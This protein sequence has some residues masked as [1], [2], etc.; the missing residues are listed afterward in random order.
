MHDEAGWYYVQ[1]NESIG[2]VTLSQLIAV[3][4]K[5]GGKDAL[6][7]GPSSTEWT[8]ARHIG[9]LAGAISGKTA[10][11]PRRPPV[12]KNDEIDYEIFGSEMQ[13]VVI[14]LDPGET[15]IAEP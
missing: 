3:L 12:R 14:E 15:V 1:D 7:F 4:P 9:E 5:I 8:E 2:P 13:Y 6:V 11:P 10:G